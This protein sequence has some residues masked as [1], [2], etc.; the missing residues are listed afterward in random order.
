MNTNNAEKVERRPKVEQKKEKKESVLPH[1]KSKPIPIPQKQ[2][3]S[4]GGFIRGGDF[5]RVGYVR[6]DFVLDETSDD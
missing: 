4:W 3:R 2:E 5:D 6:T 1:A